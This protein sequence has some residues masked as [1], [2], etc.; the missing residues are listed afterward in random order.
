MAPPRTSDRRSIPRLAGKLLAT[1]LCAVLGYWV[2][3]THCE[4]SG[5]GAG[6]AALRRACLDAMRQAI[7][8]EIARHEGWL[9]QAPGG[10]A[11]AGDVEQIRRRLEKLRA[12][13][14]RAAKMRPAN[15]APPRPVHV[16]ARLAVA[17]DG[18]R[19]LLREDAPA[20]DP[21]YVV[22]RSR[23]PI[24]PGKACRMTLYQ[25]CPRWQSGTPSYYVYVHG[26]G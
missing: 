22:I 24:Q 8:V 14:A 5:A 10:D 20:G 6:D 15:H 26:Q 25:V 17:T 7:R 18:T 2:V 12:N 9:S 11:G 19:R 4:R 16:T 23:R 21:A 1:F 3:R 13:L